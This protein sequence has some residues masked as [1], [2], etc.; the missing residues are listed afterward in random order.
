MVTY[1]KST[2]DVASS[3]TRILDFFNNALAR[4][5]SCFCPALKLAPSTATN[6]SRLANGLSLSSASSRFSGKRCT[7]LR[8]S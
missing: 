1:S 5:R 4:H 3:I 8:A 2:E 7:L 6:V